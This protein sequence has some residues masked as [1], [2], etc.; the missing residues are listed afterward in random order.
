MKLPKKINIL[1]DV[2]DVVYC[3]TINDVGGDDMPQLWGCVKF[4][5]REIRIYKHLS[6]IATMQ[7]VMHEVVHAYENKFGLDVDEKTV[8][9][10]SSLFVEFVIRNRVDKWI[11]D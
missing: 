4:K 5:E 11:T 7:T 10:I 3:D 6:D 8:E 1:S 9:L 2:Y